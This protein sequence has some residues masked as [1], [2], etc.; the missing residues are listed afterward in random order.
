MTK[1]EEQDQSAVIA[2]GRLDRARQLVAQVKQFAV[3]NAS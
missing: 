3:T 2:G 1:S